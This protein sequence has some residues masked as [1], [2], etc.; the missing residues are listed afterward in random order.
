MSHLGNEA[1]FKDWVCSM[2][3]IDSC[4][5][6]MAEAS[7]FR[8][9]DGNTRKMSTCFISRVWKWPCASSC[10]GPAV[11]SFGQ[12]FKDVQSLPFGLLR[13]VLTQ[14]GT[15]LRQHSW[16]WKFFTSLDFVGREFVHRH[17]QWT[18][19]CRDLQLTYGVVKFKETIKICLFYSTIVFI[20]AFQIG[21]WY[22]V[23]PNLQTPSFSYKV[24]TGG[25]GTARR[26]KLSKHANNGADDTWFA[27]GVSKKMCGSSLDL[28]KYWMVAS[29]AQRYQYIF[30][31]I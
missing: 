28:A 9:P 6:W 14:H 1:P 8:L 15:Q 23:V 13:G 21:G 25:K 18:H 31:T 4:N 3:A 2:V 5:I 7:F 24:R 19:F 11:S 17:L 16:T 26:T 29:D 22:G 27:V 30:C 20:E 10:K 12:K